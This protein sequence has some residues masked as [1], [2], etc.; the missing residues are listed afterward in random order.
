MKNPARKLPHRLKRLSPEQKSLLTRKLEESGFSAITQLP[1][2]PADNRDRGVLS[3][4]QERLWFLDQLGFG[5]GTYNIPGVIRIKGQLKVEVLEQALNE[6]MRRH[7]I[8]RTTFGTTQE[9]QLVQIVHP[10]QW[11]QLSMVDLEILDEGSRMEEV[12]RFVHEEE[13]QSFN[14]KEGPMVRVTLLRL[15]CREHLF[16]YTMHHIVSDGWS[17]EILNHELGVLFHAFEKEGCSPLRELEIQ[18]ADFAAWQRKWL[19]GQILETQLKYWK[20]QLRLSPNVLELPTDFPRPTTPT[21][22]GAIVRTVMNANSS[23]CLRTLCKQFGVTM[24]MAVLA[25]W[26]VLLYRYSGQDDI[27]VGTPVS[28]RNRLETEELIGLFLNTLV[29]RTDLS[30]NPRFVDLLNRERKVALDAYE[31]QDI[32][33]E[34]LVQA[35]QPERAF[36][37]NPLFQIFFNV[38]HTG[39]GTVEWPGLQ[40]S[41]ETVEMRSTSFDLTLYVN[42]NGERL[43]MDLAYSKDLFREERMCQFL[44]QFEWLIEQIV[45]V[46]EKEIDAYSLVT[47]AFEPLLP[48]L[49]SAIVEPI[50]DFVL[51]SFAGWA[52]RFPGAQALHQGERTWDYNQLYL[53]VEKMTQRLRAGGINHG[54]VVAVTGCRSF[55]LVAGILAVLNAGAILLTLDEQLPL[56]RRRLMLQEGKA[57]GI[58]YVGNSGMVVEYED[59]PLICFFIE[60]NTGECKDPLL[61]EVPKNG[62]PVMVRPEDPAYIFFTSGTTGVPKGVLGSHKGLSHFLRWQRETF[63]VGPSDRVAQLSGL[64]FDVVLRDLFLPLISGATLCLPDADGDADFNALRWIVEREITVL[65]AVPTLAQAWLD[66]CDENIAAPKLRLVFFAGEPLSDVLVNGWRKRMSEESRIINLYGPTETTLAKCFYQVPKDPI[67]G[68]QPLGKSLPQ[69]HVFL[70]RGSGQI[71]GLGEAGEIVIRTPFRSLGYVNSKE[72]NSQRFFNNPFRKDEQDMI[73]RTGDLGRYR[74]DGSIEILSRLDDQVKI[75]GVRIE[76][77]EIATVLLK[78]PAVKTCFVRGNKDQRGEISLVAYVVPFE[79]GQEMVAEL[80]NYL[81]LHVP[82]A[83]VPRWFI[84]LEQLPLNSNGKV[85]RGSLPVPVEGIGGEKYTAPRTPME[86]L[87]VGIWRDILKIER[88]GVDDNFFELGGHSLLATR[89]ASRV[90]EVFNVDLPLRN[91]F[92]AP[93]VAGISERI[94][95]LQSDGATLALPAIYPTSHDQ[96]L[97]LSYAQERLWFLNQMEPQNPTYNMAGKV[98]VRGEVDINIFDLVFREL[99][100]RHEVMRTRFEERGGEV[101][102]VVEAAVE[103]KVEIEDAKWINV[104]ER[105]KRISQVEAEI[106]QHIFDLAR[107]PLLR[108][109]IMRFGPQ[110]H[111]MYLTMHHIISDGWSMGVLVNEFGRLYE[112][113]SGRGTPLKELPVQ[114]GDYALWQRQWLKGEVLDKQLGYWRKRLAGMTVLDLPTDRASSATTSHRGGRHVVKVSREMR[115]GLEALGRKEGATLFMVLMAAFKV[116]LQQYSGQEDIAVGSPIANRNRTEIE[117]LIGFFVN[118]LVSRTDLSG[119]PSFVELLRREREAALGAYANQDVPFE[120]VVQELQPVRAINRSPLFQ[121]AFGLHN[122]PWDGVKLKGIEFEWAEMERRWA[123]FDLT[124]GVEVVAEGLRGYM[125]YRKDLFE[126]ETIGRLAGHWERVLAGFVRNPGQR[127]SE[128][129][130]LSDREREQILVG[131]NQTAREYPR[132]RCIHELFEDQVEKTPGSVAVAYEDQQLT[133]RELNERS[134]RLARYLRKLGIGPDMVV[135]IC[136]ER[137]LEMV[138]GLLGIL[139]AG[140]A[141]LPLDGNYPE[142]RLRFMLKDTGASVLLSQ[143]AWAPKFGGGKVKVICLENHWEMIEGERPDNLLNQASAENVAYVMY[144]SGSTGQ[145]KGIGIVHQGVVRLVR[146]ADYV[147]LGGEESLLQIA[148]IS[149]DASTFEIWGAL[150]NGARLRVA[151]Q[152]AV[153]ALEECQRQGLGWEISTMFLT[154]ALFNQ[155]VKERSGI[156]SGMRNLLFGGEAVDARWVREALAEQSP[157]RLLH[158]YG[159]TETTTFASWY[160]VQSSAS[161]RDNVPIGRPIAN[162]RIYILDKQFR[163]VPVGVTGEITIGGDGLARGYWKRPDLTA[164]KFVPDPFALAPGQRLYR[165]GDLGRHLA[166]GNIEFIGRR[167]HQVKLRG[168]RIELG[169]VENAL[170]SH[171][172]VSQ[173]VVVL[174]GEGQ[175]SDLIGYVVCRPTARVSIDT[176]KSH[177]RDKV[178]EYMVPTFLVILEQLPLNS[179]G[180]VDRG[181][182]PVPVEGMGR[183]KYRSPRTPMEELLVGIWQDILKIERV[184]VDDNFF[185][186]GGH[187]LQAIEFVS[188][189]RKKFNVD[190]PLRNLFEA[191]T[192]VGISKRIEK[193]QSDG[194]TLALPAIYPTSHDQPLPL[195]YEQ[196]QMWLYHS[197]QSNTFGVPHEVRMN[198][199]LEV[200]ALEMAVNEVIRRH[201]ILRT[202]YRDSEVGPVQVVQGY[203]FRQLPVI[204]LGCLDEQARGRELKVLNEDIGRRPF[205]LEKGSVFYAA[206]LQSGQG[207]YTIL[208]AVHHIATDFLSYLLQRKEIRELYNA[209][210]RCEPSPLSELPIQYADYAVWQKKRLQGKTLEDHV[211]YWKKQAAGMRLLQLQTDYP[212][213]EK[214]RAGGGALELR[215]GGAFMERLKEFNRQEGVTSFMTLLAAMSALIHRYEGSEDISITAIV[216]GR[217]C[218]ETKDMIGYFSRPLLFRTKIDQN[219]SVR[220]LLYRVRETTLEAFTHQDL[221]LYMGVAVTFQN[222]LK[223]LKRPG[224]LY[225]AIQF[226][227]F[228]SIKMLSMQSIKKIAA[229]LRSQ[230]ALKSLLVILCRFPREHNVRLIKAIIQGREIPLNWW[231]S[232]KSR[233]EIEGWIHLLIFLIELRPDS[234]RKLFASR[235]VEEVMS[236]VMEVSTQYGLGDSSCG[237]LLRKIFETTPLGRDFAN[238]KGGMKINFMAWPDDEGELKHINPGPD[239]VVRATATDIQLHVFETKLELIILAFYNRDIFQTETVRKMLGDL[240]V[241]F[242]E[243]IRDPNQ[244]MGEL[245]ISRTTF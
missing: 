221:P 242:K 24:F 165:T 32:P 157:E 137:S 51:A 107:G 8:L 153:L 13:W 170:N 149:F 37:R 48:D 93:T 164:E 172:L 180:K 21:Y 120:R 198:G 128:V 236:L 71:C 213:P 38:R 125:D 152:R 54:D 196:E 83:M 211:E 232:G 130:L 100:K 182:L 116:L 14:L 70:I 237:K 234:V 187:S 97:P 69:T 79:R 226:I 55:S 244:R 174:G 158:V 99:V 245:K 201:A 145:P 119:D 105:Q 11:R 181:S 64:S 16:L 46:P 118:T 155:M 77:N 240:E 136:M 189:A 25:A 205:D 18:Y 171:P 3:F 115:D 199:P 123:K 33:F 63:T 89:L 224:I 156:F 113:F 36:N 47:P 209:F 87:L 212:R 29:L 239:S 176:L 142:E 148:P 66:D 129:E 57:K 94:E 91:L 88:V 169:E 60:A 191:P 229:K 39:K 90:R 111:L 200:K 114:Y 202:T 184:G 162:T 225:Q 102:Q 23:A 186:L 20:K 216:A 84:F 17:M 238:N 42:D 167:D 193:L 138:I 12:K 43:S 58:L 103:L 168:H 22:R 9:E 151:S 85:D 166:D 203:Q 101:M 81:Q 30:G 231:I 104:E 188:R 68:V 220:D 31:H 194:A 35:L 109:K 7:E 26:K 106:S 215:L 27:V 143:M 40:V 183:E 6:I 117:G 243:F 78:H 190:L 132:N 178:P 108:V 73:C 53:C 74:L 62:E 34:Q 122:T 121:V 204:D 50:Q 45:S 185:E 5:G 154:T 52:R 67:P 140:G 135:G 218:V 207:D 126:A 159:P 219:P 75:R 227:I 72:G 133:Y 173:S 96:P 147:S 95:K 112:Y 44:K 82:A 2:S 127:L 163:P 206:L 230:T 150:L 177:L 61:S 210:S 59:L 195:S 228:E 192:V 131:W 124:L 15:N 175:R 141:Y 49:N 208:Y 179:N 65:H 56:R 144:T 80:R 139:K 160:H 235:D 217:N 161:I 233:E 19:Q 41:V 197:I 1:L 4:A 76:P 28:N 223:S 110:E 214:P 92:E 241:M 222:L 146:S 86:E 10:H 98:W 134:N